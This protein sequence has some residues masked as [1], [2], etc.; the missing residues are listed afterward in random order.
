MS[1][2]TQVPSINVICHII[3]IMMIIITDGTQYKRF[4]DLYGKYPNK[5]VIHVDTVIFTM[6]ILVINLL[7]RMLRLM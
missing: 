7:I 5:E 3:L 1:E 4:Y 6:M 2:R